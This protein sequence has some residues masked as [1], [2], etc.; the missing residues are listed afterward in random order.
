MLAG[1]RGA[2]EDA[3]RQAGKD[4]R[5]LFLKALTVDRRP[6]L[7]PMVV[8][9]GG[10]IA[11]GKSTVAGRVGAA[12][13]APVVSSDRTRKSMLHVE[14]T[15]R[16]EEP[17]WSGA[18]AQAV[19]DD[20]YCEV[21]RRAEVVLA[22]GRPVVL[23]ASFRSAAS[24]QAAKDLAD[25]YGAP[26]RFVECRAE[27]AVCR[28]RLAIRAKTGGVS[29]GTIAIFDDF[30]AHYEPVLEL[31]PTEH[32]VLETARPLEQNINTLAA[33]LGAWPASFVG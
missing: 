9:I 25:R 23:D 2:D 8:A 33:S 6:L 3:R 10:V 4:A 24:R 17:R 31:P 14:A 28:A 1:D 18:Y 26:F 21:L 22:S 20:V 27:A 29:D 15:R 11:T 30:A 19:T 7:V 12:L 32:I 16:L 5:R 13:S